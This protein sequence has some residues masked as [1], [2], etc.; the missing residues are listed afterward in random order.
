VSA[1]RWLVTEDLLREL[2][3]GGLQVFAWTVNDNEEALKL[4]DWGVDGITSDRLDLLRSL[5]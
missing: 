4:A 3:A 5:P 2:H 1:G